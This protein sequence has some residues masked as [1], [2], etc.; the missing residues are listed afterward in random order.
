MDRTA[1]FCEDALT[2]PSALAVANA[3]DENSRPGPTI[4]QLNGDYST[5]DELGLRG[6][7]RALVCLIEGMERPNLILDFERIGFFGSGLVNVL[8]R[9][10]Q[11]ARLCGGRLVIVRATGH[12]RQIL[13]LSGLP[14]AGALGAG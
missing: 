11:R 14:R 5:L 9:T 12:A 2:I 3:G 10:A 13:R 1:T 8:V 4:V 6:L 7:E